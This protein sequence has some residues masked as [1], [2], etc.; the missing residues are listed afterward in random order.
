M[1]EQTKLTLETAIAH[2][3]LEVADNPDEKVDVFIGKPELL[4]AEPEEWIC[5]Y[6]IVGGGKDMNFQVHGV[7]GVQALY[8]VFKMIDASIASADLSLLWLGGKNLGFVEEN[9]AH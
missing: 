1:T 4:V 8:Y 2:R 9:K 6:R 3:V 7:D 5:R